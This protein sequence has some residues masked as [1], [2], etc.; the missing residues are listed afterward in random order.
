[1]S[2]LERI[3]WALATGLAERGHRVTL[4]GAPGSAV[5]PGGDVIPYTRGVEILQRHA[6]VL[7]A[8]DLVH[9]HGW[10]LV[11]WAWARSRPERPVLQTWHGPSVGPTAQWQRPP[12][13]VKVVGVSRWHAWRLQCELGVPVVPVYNGVD[14]ARYTPR[15]TPRPDGP[16]LSL[17]RVDPLKGHHFAAWAAAR[18]HRPLWIAGPTRGVPDP[19]YVRH[20]LTTAT[21]DSVRYLGELD[22]AAKQAALAEAACLL[23]LTPGYGEPFGLG[24]VEALA[25]G[26]PVVAWGDGAL[27]ELLAPDC[28]DIVTDPW[29][30]PQAIDRAVH[31]DPGRCRRQ[32]E[33]FDVARMVAA[34]LAAYRDVQEGRWWNR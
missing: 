26:V 33:R 7:D 16:L 29:D 22:E 11:G 18:A 25:A 6:A 3:V 17:N 24:V 31:L 10:E 21:G 32:A 20:V 13:N 9:D 8:A 23:W 15:R 30:L 28:G 12:A 5:P 34:Y 19:A 14:V 4:F 27:P 1:L 2:G